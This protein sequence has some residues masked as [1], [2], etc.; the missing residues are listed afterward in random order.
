MIWLF[1]TSQR[2]LKVLNSLRCGVQY[3]NNVKANKKGSDKK[4]KD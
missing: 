3:V 1:S 4:F 2:T